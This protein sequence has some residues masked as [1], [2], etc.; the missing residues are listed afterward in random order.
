MSSFFHWFRH[1]WQF[2][3]VSF[4]VA[5]QMFVS[6]IDSWYRK[7]KNIGSKSSKS[8]KIA[9]KFRVSSGSIIFLSSFLQP[10]SNTFFFKFLGNLVF[11]NLFHLCDKVVWY[12]WYRLHA[13]SKYYGNSPAMFIYWDWL[14]VIVWVY[15]KNDFKLNYL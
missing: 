6:N 8:G 12:F 14:K 5:L 1:Y 10:I 4:I 2:L 13:G 15:H 9:L 11:N 3:N 7:R